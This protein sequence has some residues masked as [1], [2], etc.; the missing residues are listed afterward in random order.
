MRIGVW[1]HDTAAEDD[2]IGVFTIYSP[3]MD[4]EKL[5]GKPTWINLYGTPRNVSALA[6]K[7]AEPIEHGAM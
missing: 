3:L 2:P 6:G 1:D 5:W 7:K 4:I